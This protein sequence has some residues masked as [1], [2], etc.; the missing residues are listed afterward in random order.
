MLTRAN[1]QSERYGARRLRDKLLEVAPM[2]C[3]GQRFALEKEMSQ[4]QQNEPQRDDMTIL[5]VR[6]PIV[7]AAAMQLPSGAFSVTGNLIL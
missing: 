7:S 2:T 6:L 4:F 5:G 3:L 1:P